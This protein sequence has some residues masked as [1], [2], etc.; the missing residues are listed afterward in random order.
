MTRAKAVILS[1][2]LILGACTTA[3]VETGAAN[4]PVV[5]AP[6]GITSTGASKVAELSIGM[7]EAEV[8][9]VLGRYRRDVTVEPLSCR[10][11]PYANGEVTEL[12]HVYFR[13]GRLFAASDGHADPCG[14]A[15]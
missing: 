10:S 15:G 6:E 3:P 8:G 5:S 11:Y 1:I 12:A 4:A 13:N 7:T 2:G 9:N 14:L